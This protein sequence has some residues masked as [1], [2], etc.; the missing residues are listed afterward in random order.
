MGSPINLD[1]LLMLMQLSSFFDQGSK[2]PFQPM[3]VTGTFAPG[4]AWGSPEAIANAGIV[5]STYSPLPTGADR[6]SDIELVDAWLRGFASPQSAPFVSDVER[7]KQMIEEGTSGEWSPAMVSPG[8]NFNPGMVAGWVQRVNPNTKK[9]SSLTKA[10][11]TAWNLAPLASMVVPGLGPTLTGALG[12]LGVPAKL[13]ETAVG[14]AGLGGMPDFS[15]NQLLNAA[16]TMGLGNVVEGSDKKMGLYSLMDQ[17]GLVKPAPV[18]PPPATT[19]GAKLPP[20]VAEDFEKFAELTFGGFGDAGGLLPEKLPGFGGSPAD[21][22]LTTQQFVDMFQ[23]TPY[24]KP[25]ATGVGT[26]GA[27]PGGSGAPGGPGM[28]LGSMAGLAGL[29]GLL[30]NVGGL[31]GGKDDGASGGP[32]GPVYTGSP[33]GGA[34]A[35]G[36]PAYQGATALGVGAGLPKPSDV[37]EYLSAWG[38]SVA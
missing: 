14:L 22:G 32:V 24:V 30:G 36:A 21:W 25:T 4:G 5:G 38:R 11:K 9:K 10:V 26:A 2:E 17:L 35:G 3:P 15:K 37:R 20:G 18:K 8:S 19:P 34:I 28:G 33:G 12:G 6:M 13:A 16:A 7:F 23:G 31:F 1:Q 27:T 29:L